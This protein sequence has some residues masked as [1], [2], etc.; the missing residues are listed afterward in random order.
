MATSERR[1][2][3]DVR[4]ANPCRF[5]WRENDGVDWSFAPKAKRGSAKGEPAAE[6]RRR[7][8]C[9]VD[10][11]TGVKTQVGGGFSDTL[12]VLLNP[13]VVVVEV[14]RCSGV[15]VGVHPEVYSGV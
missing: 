7:K 2:V 8:T 1:K 14:N 5:E 6:S 12:G 9:L 4:L 3:Y 10:G 13:E 11:S 15:V